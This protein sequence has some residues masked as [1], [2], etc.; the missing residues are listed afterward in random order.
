MLLQAFMKRTLPY[1]TFPRRTEPWLSAASYNIA[2]YTTPAR[3]HSELSR[4]HRINNNGPVKT[5]KQV[6]WSRVET[7]FSLLFRAWDPLSRILQHTF[8]YRFAFSKQNTA[9]THRAFLA[10]KRLLQQG[11]GP[12]GTRKCFV[13]FE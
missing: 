6:G 4:T 8:S 10:T 5:E 1:P 13:Y 7:Q 9:T 11:S 12:C 3:P 2:L